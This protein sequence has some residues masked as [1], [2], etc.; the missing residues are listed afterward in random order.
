M[1]ENKQ[2]NQNLDACIVCDASN[3]GLR[4]ILEYSTD[5]AWVAIAY[6]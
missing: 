2:F 1:N 5:E 3:F 6:T 4:A